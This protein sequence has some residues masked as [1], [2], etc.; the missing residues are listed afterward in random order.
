MGSVLRVE[1]VV[2][3]APA[4]IVLVRRRHLQHLDPGVLHEAEQTRAIAAG[5]FNADALDVPER[6]HPCQHLPVSLTGGGE[7]SGSQNAILFVDD[8]RDV[9]ILVGI[10][11]AD[12]AAACFL[13]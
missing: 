2:L 6:S 13:Q 9:Q 3:A 11:A 5:R 7:A 4:P 10:D 1:I 12:D 8:G